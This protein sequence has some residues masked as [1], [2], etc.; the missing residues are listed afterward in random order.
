MKRKKGQW[1]DTALRAQ[2]ARTLDHHYRVHETQASHEQAAQQ[3]A[4]ALQSLHALASSWRQGRDTALLTKDLDQLYQR[5]HARLRD[6]AADAAKASTA[7]QLA[8][9]EA[10][11][12]LRQSHARQQALGRTVERRDRSIAKDA[13]ASERGRANEA[14]VMAQAGKKGSE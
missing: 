7:H 11:A 9:D 14:W 4:E 8:L 1:L 13:Q 12:H 6:E 3:E 10:L 2:Q 5:F